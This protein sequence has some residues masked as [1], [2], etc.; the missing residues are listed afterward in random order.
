MPE[1]LGKK[2]ERNLSAQFEEKGF[3]Y[4]RLKDDMSGFKGST[5]ICD[6]TVFHKGKL[7]YLE[8]KSI[9][10]GTFNYRLLRD[11]QYYGL[12]KKSDIKDVYAGVLLWFIDFD[13]T[14]FIPIKYIK[15]QRLL[16]VKSFSHKDIPPMCTIFKGTKKR[17][18]FD[19]DLRDAFD[20][21]V[22]LGDSYGY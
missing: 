15:G 2:F 1:S 3:C 6:F 17:V 12:L 4:D 19:Y 14:V 22:K 10:H 11:N 5:N 7:F 21:I 16:D 9:R 18:F 20:S 13:M 8:C